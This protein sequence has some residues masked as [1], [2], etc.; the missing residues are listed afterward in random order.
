[1]CVCVCVSILLWGGGGGYCWI[2]PLRKREMATCLTMFL[3]TKQVEAEVDWA[4]VVWAHCRE[5]SRPKQG[6]K[7][8]GGGQS[9]HAEN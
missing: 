7:G 4:F 3:N 2:A 6:V 9:Q 8:G 1:M 5:L